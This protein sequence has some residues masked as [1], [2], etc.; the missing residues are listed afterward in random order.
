MI[1]AVQF[2]FVF[3]KVVNVILWIDCT[4]PST[5]SCQS[6]YLVDVET[7]T[8]TGKV[9]WYSAHFATQENKLAGFRIPGVKMACEV[10]I[11]AHENHPHKWCRIIGWDCM[12]TRDGTPVFFEG[13]LACFRAPRRVCLSY[14]NAT[15]FVKALAPL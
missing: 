14:K 13:N 9:P 2:T 7:E 10:A 5:H 12:I 11:R 1:V 8:V 6:G 15:S 4:S 3:L